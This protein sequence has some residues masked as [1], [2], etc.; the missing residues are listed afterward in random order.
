MTRFT[1][2]MLLLLGL[3]GLTQADYKVLVIGSSSSFS[4]SQ[5]KDV[6]PELPYPPSPIAKELKNIL[7]K[8]SAIKGDVKVVVDDVFREKLILSAVGQR[9]PKPWSCT[10]HA[11]SLAQYYFW[12]EGQKERIANLRGEAENKWDA[13][14]IMGD[15]YLIAN[16][17]GIY[18]EGVQL[19]VKDILAGGATP[20]LLMQLPDDKKKINHFAEVIARVGDSDKV[21]VAPAALAWKKLRKKSLKDRSYLA[22]SSIYSVLFNKSASKSKYRYSSSIAKEALSSVKSYTSKYDSMFAFATPFTMKSVHKRQYNVHHTGSSSEHG[23][24]SGLKRVLA[25]G[26]VTF[27]LKAK[28]IKKYDFNL[29][30]GNSNFEAKK[31]YKV[32]PV[33][34]ERSYGFPMG[35]RRDMDPKKRDGKGAAVSMLYGIDKRFMNGRHED[36]TDLG[37]AYDMIRQDEVKKD[38]RCIPIRLLHSKMLA[39]VKELTPN[40]DGWHLSNYIDEAAATYIYTSLT[41]RC[42][43]GDEP[44]LAS[45]KKHSN[46]EWRRWMARRIGYETAWRLSHLSPRVPGLEILPSAT[47][48]TSIM[49]GDSEKMT[50]RFLYPPIAPVTVKVLVEGAMESTVTPDELTFTPENYLESQVV[51]VKAAG[52]GQLKINFLSESEDTVYKELSDSWI[53]NVGKTTAAK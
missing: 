24:S 31:Q 36:G 38:V 33:L 7:E 15:P 2:F 19:L 50:V 43:I 47:S 29:G 41:G 44:A 4:K 18:S 9:S 30:R 49:S 40:R 25:R 8:D 5:E 11:Y 23:I 34:F 6:V 53:Y 10:Y 37:I 39:I 28:G 16:M 35:E 48:V 14:V 26:K 13:V 45:E 52:S 3:S 20:V 21:L 12:P 51:A 1:V 32:N 22:A 46:E 42:P 27:A 17:P